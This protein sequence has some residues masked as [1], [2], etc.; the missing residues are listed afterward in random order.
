[1]LPLVLL[2]IPSASMLLL[3]LLF[4]VLSSAR[5]Q[6]PSVCLTLLLWELL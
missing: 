2:I 1:L 3:L 6:G 5:Q 4:R